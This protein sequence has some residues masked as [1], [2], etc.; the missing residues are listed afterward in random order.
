MR[1]T[2]GN[3]EQEDYIQGIISERIEAVRN[4]KADTLDLT[5][6]LLS[7]IPS[8]VFELIN[9]RKLVLSADCVV[10]SESVYLD[11]EFWWEV[12]FDNNRIST[13][14]GDIQ[15]LENLEVLELNQVGLLSLPPEIGNLH[16]LR[17][18]H[19]RN[20]RLLVLPKEIGDLPNLGILDVSFN[21]LESLPP[22]ICGLQN[23]RYLDLGSNAL[24]EL[25][26][27]MV[28][29]TNLEYFSIEN[30]DPDKVFKETVERFGLNRNKIKTLPSGL[31]D[32]PNLDD[33]RFDG[34]PL[35]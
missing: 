34:N 1:V 4:G 27:A 2:Y 19:L 35:A 26:D 13:L 28:R 24:T 15:K 29:L 3:G 30:Y 8:P 23:L 11:E 20:N 16:N 33:F 10:D 21:G 9:C 17:E 25:P 32:L 5:K 18:L 6:L 14:P 7:G 12:G 22:E 31:G